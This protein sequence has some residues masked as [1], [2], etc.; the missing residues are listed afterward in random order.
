[1]IKIYKASIMEFVSNMV[2]SLRVSSVIEK[3]IEIGVEL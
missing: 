1:M 2:A 3:V